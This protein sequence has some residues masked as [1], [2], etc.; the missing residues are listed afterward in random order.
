MQRDLDHQPECHA[1]QDWHISNL[2]DEVN[3]SLRSATFQNQHGSEMS[4]LRRIH[5][6][7]QMMMSRY[8]SR[9]PY[10][11]FSFI[12]GY[13]GYKLFWFLSP[14][15]SLLSSRANTPWGYGWRAW[16]G[17]G[18]AISW[19]TKCWHFGSHT[20]GQGDLPWLITKHVGMVSRLFY[21]TTLSFT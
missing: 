12:I 7:L 20:R 16:F 3:K 1:E 9:T 5:I 2:S 14:W 10:Q 21:I 18:V 8:H 6:L 13:K 17:Q 15:W 11:P 19:P 4:F